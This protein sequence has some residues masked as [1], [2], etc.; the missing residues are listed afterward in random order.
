MSETND[1]KPT[2]IEA[3]SPAQELSEEALDQVSGGIRLHPRPRK[4]IQ[5]EGDP[6]VVTKPPHVVDL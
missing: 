1:S 2:E 6:R 5:L 3:A 4:D